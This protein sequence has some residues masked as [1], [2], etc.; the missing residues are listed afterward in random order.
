VLESGSSHSVTIIV[1]ENTKSPVSG[2]F[3]LLALTTSPCAAL[4]AFCGARRPSARPRQPHHVVSWHPLLGDRQHMGRPR[5]ERGALLGCPI[6]TL[7]H[8]GHAAAAAPDVVEHGLRHP[9]PR[10]RARPLKAYPNST[11]V[12]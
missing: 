8:A 5:V 9:E 7:V 6:V 12:Q 4:V 3:H 11:Y 10:Y 1:H 2:F